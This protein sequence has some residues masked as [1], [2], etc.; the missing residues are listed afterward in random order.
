M[1]IKNRCN[2]HT[3]TDVDP[4][5]HKAES[6]V[7]NYEIIEAHWQRAEIRNHLITTFCVSMLILIIRKLP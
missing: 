3:Q 7:K 5:Y 4:L 1:Y 2:V 6:I